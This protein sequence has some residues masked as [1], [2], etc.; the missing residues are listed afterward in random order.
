MVTEIKA[1]TRKVAYPD[2]SAWRQSARPEQLPPEDF[3]AGSVRTWF[4]RGGRGSG[5][6]WVAS[7][8]FAENITA[9]DGAGEWAIIAPTYRRLRRDCLESTDSGLLVALGGEASPWVR[10]YN[11]SVLELNLSNGATVILAS[12]EDGARAIQGKNLRG[13]WLEEIGLWTNWET[14]FDESL[15]YALRKGRAQMII[16]GTPKY[17]QPAAKLVQRLLDDPSVPVTTLKTM[18]NAANLSEKMLEDVRQMLGTRLGRQELEGELLEDNPDALWVPSTIENTRVH[19][20]PDL[21]RVVVSVDPAVAGEKRWD[22]LAEVM[23]KPDDEYYG[24]GGTGAP[25]ETGIIVMG[26]GADGHGYVL[27]DLSGHF[28]PR[29]SAEVIVAAYHSWEADHVV[30]EV[31]NGGDYI[32]ALIATVDTSVPVRTVH[33]SRGKVTRAE[34]IAAA[35]AAGRIHHVGT[36]GDLESQ[37]VSW[38]PGRGSPDRVDALVWGATDLKITAATVGWGD[39]WDPPQEVKDGFKTSRSANQWLAVYAPDQVKEAVETVKTAVRPGSGK[40]AAALA[41]MIREAL[42]S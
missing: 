14:A 26:V 40:R 29:R 9:P 3:D 34:P 38:V 35:Y 28:N 30:A 13:A 17:G 19:D 8:W 18:D 41:Q 10:S 31:N 42:E 7:H 4:L 25:D 2:M 16:T 36:F 6:S 27:A 39:I 11:R 24:S 37:M 15:R 22:M 32:P 5:K 20:H 33:A 21:S 1:R 23:D 12:S